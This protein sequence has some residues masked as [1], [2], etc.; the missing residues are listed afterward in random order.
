MPPIRPSII[1]NRG[2]PAAGYSVQWIHATLPPGTLD[3]RRRHQARHGRRAGQDAHAC[4]QLRGT[5]QSDVPMYP[6]RVTARSMTCRKLCACMF[7]GSTARRRSGVS[8]SSPPEL[9][10][11]VRQGKEEGRTGRIKGGKGERDLTIELARVRVVAELVVPDSNVVRALAAVA[12]RRRVDF[13]D[14]HG[15]SSKG[16]EN[17]SVGEEGDTHPAAA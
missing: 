6:S 2:P 4:C 7:S 12:W 15:F 17:G 14:Q 11:K 9:E 10:A 5:E 1:A 13:C 16:R 3:Q 8:C